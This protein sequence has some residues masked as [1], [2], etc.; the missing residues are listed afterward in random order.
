M[1]AFDE[2][3]QEICYQTIHVSQW[4]HTYYAV[5]GAEEFQV[6]DAELQVAPEV[7]L[8]N[9]YTLGESGRAGGVVYQ[10]QVVGLGNE[11]LDV[12]RGKALGVA[13]AEQLVQGLTG[14]G[15]RFGARGQQR[16]VAQHKRALQ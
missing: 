8:S 14:L 1:A 4:Q 6:V 12:G 16:E 5:A 10:H 13:V 3:V 2:C 9:H 11:I 15:K 7:A